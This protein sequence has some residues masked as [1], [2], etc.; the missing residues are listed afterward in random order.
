MI[1]P[2][3]GKLIERE[4][5]ADKAEKILS[6]IG[7]FYNIQINTEQAQEIENIT[8]GVFSPLEGFLTQDEYESVLE[9]SRLTTDV[10]WTIPIILDISENDAKLIKP[11]DSIAL[12]GPE[13]PIAIMDVED[14]YQIDKKSH[15]QKVF[16]TTDEKHPG[17]TRTLEMQDHI[18]GGHIELIKAQDS[19]FNKYYLKPKESRVLFQEMGWNKI[20]A[21]QT[22]NPPHVG[23][24]YVQKAALTLVDGLLINPIIGKKKLGDFRD[25][26][27]LSSYKTLI[28]NYY[29][30]EHAT[31][32]ILKTEMR[33]GGPKEAIHHSIMRKNFGCT[34][35]IVGRDHAGVGDFYGPYD[36]H[37][38]FKEFPDLEIEPVFFKSFSHCKICGGPVNEKICPHNSKDHIFFKGTMVREIVSTGNIP[39]KEMM[40]PEVVDV[41]KSYQQPFVE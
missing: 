22:R 16:G 18:I 1:R 17:V 34:H 3:G 29:P 38:I 10:P 21:F 25:D 13:G 19:Q 39:P 2:H 35:F 32:S 28:D 30:K 20:V 15:A 4:M 11:T 5:S 12:I 6:G 7:D 24:E 8:D 37:E 33:Y 27:I 40:R 9:H 36:A 14:I 31:M 41:I 26:V 23:H